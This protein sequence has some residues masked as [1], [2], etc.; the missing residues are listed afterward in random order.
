MCR[1]VNTLMRNVQRQTERLIGRLCL[2]GCELK[3]AGDI[4]PVQF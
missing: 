1:H 4:P 2:E 3:N